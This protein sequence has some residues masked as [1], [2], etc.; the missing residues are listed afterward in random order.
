MP[1]G[2]FTSI[3]ADTEWFRQLEQAIDDLM[4]LINSPS[5]PPSTSMQH[6]AQRHR[7]NLDDYRR[8]FIRTRVSIS[9][10]GGG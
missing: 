8:D 3:H 10:A 1:R 7:D 9:V 6:A 4:G 2:S 5:Q